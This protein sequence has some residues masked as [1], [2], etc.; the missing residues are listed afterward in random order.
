MKIFRKNQL[1]I[2]A[3]AALIAVAG[4]LN[5]IEKSEQKGTLAGAKITKET[6][7]TVQP[8]TQQETQEAQQAAGTDIESNEIDMQGEPGEAVL[9]NAA[10]TV[11]FIVE[12]K[13]AREEVRANTKETLMQI[14]N[15]ESLSEEEKSSAVE[16]VV[17]LTEDAEK[18]STAESLIQAKGYKNVAVTIS[19]DGVD[20]MVVADSLDRAARAQIEEIVK[21]KAGVSADKITIT[22]VKNIEK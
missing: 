10:G 19:E 8:E 13:L 11:D 6:E 12:A 7:S 1:V 16:K 15:N 5:H 14:V 18:E 17:E 21:S 20:V 9:V 22:A 2:T 3:L 4:Y